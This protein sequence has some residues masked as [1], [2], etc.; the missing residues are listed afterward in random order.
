MILFNNK[1]LAA[2]LYSAKSEID[3]ILLW[4]SKLRCDYLFVTINAKR[5]T[6]KQKLRTDKQTCNV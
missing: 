3:A 5:Q 6:T 4:L 1:S 2:I